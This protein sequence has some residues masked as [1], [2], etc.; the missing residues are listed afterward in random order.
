MSGETAQA[1]AAF[2]LAAIPGV[3]V[4]EIVEGGRPPLRDR[5]GIRAFA[6]YLMLSLAVWAVAAL[7][8]DAGG[9]LAAV[10]DASELAGQHRVD[11]YSVLAWRLLVAAVAVGVSLRALLWLVEKLAG[12]VERKRRDGNPRALGW[13]GDLAIG[14]VSIAFG[15]DR[16]LMRLRREALAQIVHIR[17]RDGTEMYGLLAAGGSADFQ[18][19]GRGLVLDAELLELDGRLEQIQG[20]SGVFVSP[21]AV[22]SVAFVAYSEPD[23]VGD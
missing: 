16:L 14:I 22:A 13:I 11:A 21:D 23:P 7:L 20:S 8:L 1:I 12:R 6:A 15:W 9:R 10:I 4:L 18:A 19:D 17:F 5:H 3:L 2:A